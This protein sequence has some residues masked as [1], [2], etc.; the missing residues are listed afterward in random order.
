MV[1]VSLLKLLRLFSTA[2]K[3]M[4]CERACVRVY[5]FPSTICSGPVRAPPAEPPLR[6]FPCQL[7]DILLDPSAQHLLIPHT[8]SLLFVAGLHWPVLLTLQRRPVFSGSAPGI[9]W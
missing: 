1:I 3:Y 9:I 6:V 4:C 5:F 8:P 7:S 2:F